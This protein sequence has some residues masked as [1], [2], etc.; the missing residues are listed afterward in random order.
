MT[1]E[2]GLIAFRVW[3]IQ[4]YEEVIHLHESLVSNFLSAIAVLYLG[5]SL[6]DRR[7]V[8]LTHGATLGKSYTTQ[9][10]PQGVSWKPHGTSWNLQTIAN[11]D[12]PNNITRSFLKLQG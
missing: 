2:Y 1:V 8:G 4:L 11:Q 9:K 3:V 5:S 7:M 6:I 12:K 10:K